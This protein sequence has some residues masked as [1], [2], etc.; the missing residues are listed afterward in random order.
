MR[1]PEVKVKRYRWVHASCI[2]GRWVE[3]SGFSNRA[4]LRDANPLIQA[5]GKDSCLCMY[6]KIENVVV[7]QK[8]IK[9]S[10]F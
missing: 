3:S 2:K 5:D 1:R 10:L 8:L 9:D 7:C 6:L 4:Y